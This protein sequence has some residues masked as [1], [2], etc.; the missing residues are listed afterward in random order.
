MRF[1]FGHLRLCT[2]CVHPGR[3]IEGIEEFVGR[4]MLGVAKSTTESRSGGI[5]G[6]QRAQGDMKK[7]GLRLEATTFSNRQA[8]AFATAAD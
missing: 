8:R 5:G 6:E 7:P 3:K 1:A 4:K 2:D